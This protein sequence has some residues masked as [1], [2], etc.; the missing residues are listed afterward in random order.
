MCHC[1][2]SHFV[3][4]LASFLKLVLQ[5]DI[6]SGNKDM[7]A[8]LRRLF[9]CL[10]GGIYVRGNSACQSADAALLD[11]ASNAPDRFKVARR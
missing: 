4:L 1:R 10:P 9:N 7:D 3:H 6:R 11:F 8:G 5:V 2:Y